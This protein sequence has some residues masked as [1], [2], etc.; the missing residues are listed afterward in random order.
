MRI[1]TMPTMRGFSALAFVCALFAA[2]ASS[3][4]GGG[5]GDDGPQTETPVCGDAVCA[6][7]EVGMCT[8]DCGSGSTFICGNNS[9]EGNEPS[10]CPQDCPA[11]SMCGNGTCDPTESNSSCP[12]DCTS[13]G[14]GGGNC[15]ADIT[16]CLPCLLVD[17]CIPP[18]DANTCTTCALGGLG[19][20]CLGGLPNG[21]CETGEDATNCP[22]D[23]M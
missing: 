8:Q 16:E 5:G 17:L 21:T 14:G 2:C 9:C 22:F 4:D 19:G 3:D 13:T 10:T 20:G 12:T 23:C 1:S 6:A 18:L 15:P 7:S 11:Q